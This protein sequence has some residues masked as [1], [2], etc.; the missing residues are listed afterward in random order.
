MPYQDYR[1]LTDA[2][3]RL[4]IKPPAGFNPGQ[5]STSA[6]GALSDIVS[7][8]SGRA[9]LDR[10]RAQGVL[11][12]DAARQRGVGPANPI[13]RLGSGVTAP[14]IGNPTSRNIIP[15]T[16]TGPAPTSGP[17]VG[18]PALTR[19]FMKGGLPRN[20]PVRNFGGLL[21]G[22]MALMGG[23][24]G[25]GL[26]LGPIIGERAVALGKY[27][28]TPQG[29]QI[30]ENFANPI[31]FLQR[32]YQNMVSPPVRLEQVQ[33]TM[34]QGITLEQAANTVFG[35]Q[36]QDAVDPVPPVLDPVPPA[37]DT[38]SLSQL[39]DSFILQNNAPVIV[40]A[41]SVP[42][43][44][45]GNIAG[46]NLYDQARQAAIQQG[47]QQDLN[48]VTDLG[49]AQWRANFPGLAGSPLSPEAL[50]RDAQQEELAIEAQDF[51]QK[52]KKLMEANKE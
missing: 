26:T 11:N 12:I 41:P 10:A 9:S 29:E 28:R 47:T 14:T 20:V 35:Q 16:I 40:T 43:Q 49:L 6:T 33:P 15:P 7:D 52:Y 4:G 36:L 2:F 13:N 17:Y 31:G 42:G 39:S 5:M 44:E 37:V 34:P 32:Q 19:Q 48:R 22:P 8:P 27:L 51:M 3:A 21:R 45:M 24:V 25:T 46:N 30:K 50:Q 23:A 1:F 38:S 18:D